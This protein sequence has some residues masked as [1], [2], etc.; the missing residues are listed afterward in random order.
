MRILIL[1]CVPVV[2][3]GCG[4]HDGGGMDASAD[5]MQPV[6]IAMEAACTDT[7]DSIYAAPGTLPSEPGAIIR[8]A[9]DKDLTRAELQAALD[10]DGFLPRAVD[11]GA[12]SYRVLYK[13]ERG[14]S[15]PIPGYASAVVFLPDTPRAAQLP[16]VVAAHGTRGQSANCG[17][18]KLDPSDDPVNPA[19]R[20]LAYPLVGYGYAIIAPDNAGFANFNAAGNPQPGYLNAA[21]EGRSILDAA[22]ALRKLIPSSLTDGTVLV[23]HSQGGH[24]VL[25]ALS[26]AETYGAGINLKGVAGLAPL[27]IP[28]RTFGA[29]VALASSYPFAT[30]PDANAF[31]IWYHYAAGELLDGPGH[32]VDAFAAAKQAGVKDLVESVCYPATWEK[33]TALGTNLNDIMDP[34]F[35]NSVPSVAA[36]IQASCTAGDT[37]CDR[38]MQRYFDDRPHLTGSAKTVP[39]FFAWGGKDD[40]I[41]SD[42]IICALDRLHGDAANVQTVCVDPNAT[43]GGMSGAKADVVADWIAQQALGGPAPAVCPSTMVTDAMGQPAV[44]AVLPPNMP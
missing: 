12:H 14:T 6:G 27:W 20:M 19:F 41:T 44:C 40:T 43:H 7:I 34:T 8:C 2:V 35:L 30:A 3:L 4:D 17:P 32:G 16:V 9:K 18:S 39:I 33:L 10:A 15:P 11:G 21:D 38:W 26:L 23:G 28:I 1:A 37:L 13:T 24:G 25:S 22:R 31:T 36:G 5:L 42:R 29:V